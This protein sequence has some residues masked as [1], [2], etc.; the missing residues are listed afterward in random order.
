MIVLLLA[1]S[2]LALQIEDADVE[3]LV[4]LMRLPLPLG[5]PILHRVFTNLCG[6]QQ[7]RQ[8]MLRL[9]ISLLST[10]AT[11]GGDRDQPGTGHLLL[12][13]VVTFTSAFSGSEAIQQG[14]RLAP[15]DI[16]NSTKS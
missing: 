1:I 12:L 13:Q 4:N 2:M 11:A 16:V 8:T 14:N 3:V 7:T 9:L 15:P 5:K 6:H 10:A